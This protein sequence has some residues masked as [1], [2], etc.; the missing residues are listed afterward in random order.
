MATD[1]DIVRFVEDGLLEP[2]EHQQKWKLAVIDDDEAVHD[3][4]RYALKGYRLEGA[5]LE[6]LSAYSAE[7]GRVLLENHPDTA[8]VLLDVVM[9]TEL[10]GLEL[11]P[12][13]RNELK[14]E[15]LRVI[16]RT[17]QPGQAPERDVI[18]R[19]DINDYK[20]KTELTAD[21]LFTT[22]TSALRGY[23]QLTRMQRT[24]EG[25]ALIVDAAATLF[26][27]NSLQRLAEG[28]L[29]QL[30]S[31]L[32]VQCAGILVLKGAGQERLSVLAASGCYTPLLTDP[33]GLDTVSDLH[34]MIHRTL[35][36]KTNEFISERSLIYIPTT[37]GSEVVALIEAGKPLSETDRSL[38]EVFCSRLSVAFDNVVLYEQLQQ[39]NTSLEARVRKRTAELSE[40]NDRL[41]SQ[42]LRAR[43]ERAY[44]SEVLGTVAH[45]IRNPLGV[46]LGRAEIMEEIVRQETFD[47][48]LLLHQ[49]E[50]IKESAQRLTTMVTDLITDARADAIDGQMRHE[51]VDLSAMAREVV[52][53]NTLMARKKNQQVHLQ[54]DHPILIRCDVDRMRDAID[55]LMSNAVKYSPRGGNIWVN[56]TKDRSAATLAV[57]DSGPGLLPQDMG[58]LFGRYQRLSARPTGGE[59]STGL[60][61]SIAKR[62]VD[63]HGGDLTVD[64][65]GAGQGS[66]FSINLPLASD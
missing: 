18:V 14:L 34:A 48:K 23:R 19:Y 1:P 35:E 21:R 10:A 12:F 28:I 46:I 9:E 30:E 8:V 51:L 25:L 60:G 37:R 33:V 58:R 2:V 47:G 38:V 29:T 53:A 44:Q 54:V 13:I 27:I 31:L 59:S 64:S 32:A 52:E 26:D 17:G 66:T 3:G 62:I 20:A 7:E 43:R 5:E 24:K 36:N 50:Q 41:Q 11:V 16:L 56:V 49:L 22:V 57:R 63:L 45:D 39:A 42:W 61:L 40:A 15:A 4:T 65:S 55:N 6:I